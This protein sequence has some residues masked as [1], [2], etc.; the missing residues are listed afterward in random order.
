MKNRATVAMKQSLAVQENIVL[1]GDTNAHDTMFGGLLMKRI[2]ETAAI[3]ARRHSR[4]AV[5]T[6]SNDGVHFHRPV[7]RDDIVTL[8]SYVCCVG[9]SSMEI[10]VK[11]MTE[12]ASRDEPGQIAAISFLTFVALDEAGRPTEVPDVQPESREE[13]AVFEDAMA[14]KKIRL[15]KRSETNELI[16]VLS[17]IGD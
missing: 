16:S 14:R 1:P 8:T 7:Q 3:S 11:I 4:G 9:S 10:F 13:L 17:R 6:A 5:V 2:D 15:S 12:N